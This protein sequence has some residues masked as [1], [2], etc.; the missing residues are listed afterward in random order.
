[1]RANPLRLLFRRGRHRNPLSALLVRRK[2]ARVNVAGLG[3][4]ELDGA[5]FDTQVMWGLGGQWVIVIP[6]LQLVIA[7]NSN[8]YDNSDAALN[9]AHTLVREF[10][11]PASN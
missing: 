9:Q 1:M 7:I 5:R 8:G 4:Y 6:Q 3:H 10:I 2:K 11:I